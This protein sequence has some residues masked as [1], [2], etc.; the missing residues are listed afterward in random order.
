[1]IIYM[2][3]KITMRSVL[4]MTLLIAGLYFTS[5]AQAD[6]HFMQA[7][8][9]YNNGEFGKAKSI[10]EKLITNEKYKDLVFDNYINTLIQLQDYSDAEKLIRKNIKDSPESYHYRIILGQLYL[11]QGK[12]GDAEKIFNDA[13]RNLPADA[14]QISQ[15]ASGFYRIN[16]FDYAL[17][18]FLN[19][20][21]V[22][23]D[24]QQ[25]AFELINLYRY[26]K[27]KEALSA[28]LLNVLEFRPDYLMTAKSN[29]S[30]TFEDD[31]DYRALKAVLLKKIQ[32]A[33]QNIVF[34]DLLAWTF[35]QLRE[36]DMALVQTIAID[37]RTNANGSGVF[38]LA[39]LLKDDN[40][41]ASAEKAFN[42]IVE[43]G[44]NNPYYIA[45]K[46]E[47][48]K[49]KQQQINKQGNLEQN[50]AE[51]EKAYEQLLAKF[52][53]GKQTLFAIIELAKLKANVLN[54]AN[55]AEVLLED[56]LNFKNVN[57]EEVAALK[58]ELADIYLLNNNPWDASLL[59][60]QIEKAHP[61]TAIGQEAK[62]SNAKLAFYNGDFKWAKAQLDVLKASTSQ[63]IA[64]DALDLS[65]LI[66][67]HLDLDSSGE[68]LKL[69]ARAELLRSKNQFEA[70]LVLLDSI[71]LKYPATD[72]LDDILLSKARIY[73][74]QKKYSEAIAAYQSIVTDYTSSIWADDALYSI[75][76][77][78]EDILND[79]GKAK[80]FYEKLIHEHPGSLFVIDARKRFRNI[81]GDVL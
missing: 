29:I 14:F 27:Q 5:F 33:P 74:S 24:N 26:L 3:Y 66:Q 32:I 68:A 13:I 38:T 41:W 56:A 6:N 30:R 76:V 62:F 10:Y 9:F 19:G 4:L 36:Y 7:Q 51:Q 77:L 46:L 72:L 15:V 34:S 64:N 80:Y 59:Y 18:T 50:A 31:D 21:K 57:T 37:K 53:K 67:D 47:L 25:F 11:Q 42:Y 54:K 58:L 20:R 55:E 49:I 60:G 1:M 52:G 22:L 2:S 40:A 17:S 39:N 45:A 78:Y 69:Y 16:K 71:T 35:T 28:E 63:L 65:L 48:L 79:S 44:S 73:S 8:Q 75:G 61:N 12:A 70:T 81:R 23:K 43:K